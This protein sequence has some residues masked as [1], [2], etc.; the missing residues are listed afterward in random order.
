MIQEFIEKLS[1]KLIMCIIFLKE[2]MF[3]A[4]MQAC[5]NMYKTDLLDFRTVQLYQQVYFSHERKKN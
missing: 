3:E 5:N 4:S 1:K 2:W